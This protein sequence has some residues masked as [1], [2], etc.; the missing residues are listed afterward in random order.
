MST[1]FEQDQVAILSS[2]VSNDA[3]EVTNASSEMQEWVALD[4]WRV[5]TLSDAASWEAHMLSSYQQWK[6]LTVHHEKVLKYRDA[7]SD[8]IQ[9]HRNIIADLIQCKR[10]QLYQQSFRSKKV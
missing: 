1:S 2:W 10:D 7:C 9:A 6:A 5:Q 3:K 4:T 8:A